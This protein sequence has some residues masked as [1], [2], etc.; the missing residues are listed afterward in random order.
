MLEGLVCVSTLLEVAAWRGIFAKGV[1]LGCH[2]KGSAVMGGE[3]TERAV[4]LW[5]RVTVALV[6]AH[7]WWC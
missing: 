2:P 5:N 3:G 4:R 7:P 6:D 1:G